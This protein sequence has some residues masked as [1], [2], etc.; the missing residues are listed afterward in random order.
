MRPQRLLLLVGV[1]LGLLIVFFAP[2]WTGYDEHTHFHRTADMANGSLFP[3]SD[4][5]YADEPLGQA[6][7][8]GFA[9]TPVPA[10]YVEDSNFVAGSWVAGNPAW[11]LGSVGDLLGSRPDGRMVNVDLRPTRASPPTAY[12]PAAAAMVI[13]RRADVPAVVA[14]WAGRLGNLAA[15]LA[16]AALAVRT[17]SAFRWTL[18]A[19][20]L[21]PMHLAL[22]ATI[23]P[24]ALTVGALF[25]VVALWTRIRAGDDP[26]LWLFVS[27]TLLLALAKPPYFLVLA[28]LPAAGLRRRTPEGLLAA[29]VG[30]GAL[31]LGFL[32][33]L[34]NSSTKYQAATS[35]MGYGELAFQ[36][37]VQ[38]DRLLGDIPGFLWASVEAWFTELHHYVQDWFRNYGFFTSGLP[39]ALSWLF[40]VLL[41]VALLR[42]D[43]DDF[44]ALRGHDRWTVGLGSAGMVLVL[45]GSS[46][47]YFTD[48]VAYDTIGQQMARYSAPL[49]VMMVVA[50]APRRLVREVERLPE[51][52]ARLV[53]TAVPVIATASILLTWLV[54]GTVDRY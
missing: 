40:L 47:V 44:A 12:L 25:L 39:A 34:L 23:S 9:A 35:T 29:R 48:H 4:T 38:R 30:G 26:P 6:E 32:V 37:D 51:D 49:L 11:T 31:G 14:L 7:E 5:R 28:L 43:G 19:A 22:G 41:L 52:V 24:D 17:A 1:P 54:T 16:L 2:A 27:A 20:A 13:P 50:W 18:A 36:P 53:V 42:L 33:T 46:Y 45:F 21:L 10:T 8:A 15:Y 3:S